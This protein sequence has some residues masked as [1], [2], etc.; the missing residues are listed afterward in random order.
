MLKTRL[1]FRTKMSDVLDLYPGDNETHFLYEHL[2][3]IW[4]PG[5]MVCHIPECTRTDKIPSLRA[6]IRHWQAVHVPT[7]TLFNCDHLDCLGEPWFTSRNELTRHIMKKHKLTRTEASRLSHVYPTKLETNLKYINPRENLP[8]KRLSLNAEMARQTD[9]LRRQ[10]QIGVMP[11]LEGKGKIEINAVCRDEFVTFDPVT[12][13]PTGKQ[14]RRRRRPAEATESH[15][16]EE[17]PS[18][19]EKK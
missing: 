8:P 13:T 9:R 15:A 4:T 11:D 2:R 16:P 5:G 6:F 10:Q 1:C 18:E 14:Y 12:C 17:T 19:N 7:I 3:P